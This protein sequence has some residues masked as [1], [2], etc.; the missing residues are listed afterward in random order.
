MAEYEAPSEVDDEESAAEKLPPSGSQVELTNFHAG[1]EGTSPTESLTDPHRNR[2]SRGAGTDVPS[3]SAEAVG[4]SAVTSGSEPHASLTS[5]LHSLSLA[6]SIP[7]PTP[8]T[9]LGS[10][11]AEDHDLALHSGGQGRSDASHMQGGPEKLLTQEEGGDRDGLTSREPAT[12][13]LDPH[14]ELPDIALQR[15]DSSGS[16][17]TA[18]SPIATPT[19]ANSRHESATSTDGQ[20]YGH[21][22]GVSPYVM[23]KKDLANVSQFESPG[24]L[25]ARATQERHNWDMLKPADEVCQ[26]DRQLHVVC[27]V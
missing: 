7:H 4:V 2:H 22:L 13:V 6:P 19:N 18:S 1:R 20:S 17:F 23:V 12:S 11:S 15:V 14:Q 3:T 5:Q 16:G 24:L 27:C 8:L 21:E 25:Y 26:D 10:S 9:S